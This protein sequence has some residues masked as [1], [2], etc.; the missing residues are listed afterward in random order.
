MSEIEV[1]VRKLVELNVRFSTSHATE[2]GGCEVS[3]S[4]EDV[5]AYAADPD[6]FLAKHYG[7]SKDDY[8]GWHA[9]N[10]RVICAGKTAK[11][12]PCKGTVKGLSLVSAPRVWAK[13][14]GAFCQLHATP[15]GHA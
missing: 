4:G 6:A 13:Y 9:S 1:V 12:Q 3:M 14:Q 11:G 7:V 10:Y 15:K 8:L 2:S 5:I